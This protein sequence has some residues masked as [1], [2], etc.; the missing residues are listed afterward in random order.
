MS[1]TN[2]ILAGAVPTTIL[3]L[4]VDYILGFIE[5]KA[6][7]RGF[8]HIFMNKKSRGIFLGSIV[9]LLVVFIGFNTYIKSTAPET[10]I[11]G[12]K[13][14]TESRL[15]GQM[16]SIYIE[17]NTDL[18]TDVRELGGTLPNFQAIRNGD[19]DIYTE[20]TG[21]GY[22]TIL[23]KEGDVPS[24][25]EVYDTVK[26]EFN[27]SYGVTWLK[28]LGFN[29]TYTLA[30]RKDTAEQYNLETFSDLAPISD[31]FIFGPTAEFVERPDGYP[32]LST[33]YNFNFNN[34]RTLD[35][36]LRY[37]AIDKNQ[38]QVIDAFS[39]DGK[40]QELNLV[41]L[42]DDKEYFPPYY[43]VPLINN[44]T[45]EKFPELKTLLNDL[46]GVLSDEEMQRL[47]YEVDV[48]K[49]DTISVVEN[50]LRENNLIE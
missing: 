2:L 20:Y 40:L 36:G 24:P 50:F 11:I 14:F 5:R 10:I 48:E 26:K 32:G 8:V 22:I 6:P 34:I 43:A 12:T 19:I 37:N 31:K 35:A 3:A 23:K 44:E 33:V 41:I 4:F 9:T 47:N 15:L 46:E 16:L 21:T 7:V 38:V 18:N 30:V 27:D 39:T 13:N 45:L 17:K 49:Q 29:N 28:P 1:D 25:Q 42:K